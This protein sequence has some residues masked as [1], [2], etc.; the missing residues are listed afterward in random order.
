[1]AVEKRAHSRLGDAGRDAGP[2]GKIFQRLF[3][4]GIM[5]APAYYE[6]R[7]PGLFD[8]KRGLRYLLRPA[9][10]A[11][12][13]IYFFVKELPCF[14]AKNEQSMVHTASAFAKAKCRMEIL[15]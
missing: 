11:D 3:R 9:A 4:F 1:M 13:G 14:Q 2:A 8:Q 15:A 5:N 10:P 6:E 7:P 12:N